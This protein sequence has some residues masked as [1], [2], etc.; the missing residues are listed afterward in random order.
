MKNEI[1][2]HKSQYLI[3]GESYDQVAGNKCNR[4][5]RLLVVFMVFSAVRRGTKQQIN[6][7]KKES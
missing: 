3:N 5:D 2:S 6:E 4:V 1:F 7:K